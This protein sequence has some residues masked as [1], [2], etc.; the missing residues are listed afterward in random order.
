MPSIPPIL[1]TPSSRMIYYN[2]DQTLLDTILGDGETGW[3]TISAA[4]GESQQGFPDTT[5]VEVRIVTHR[6]HHPTLHH[7]LLHS[8][9]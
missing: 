2:I 5:F 4:I 6:T 7:C 3:L 1:D 9:S 8:K